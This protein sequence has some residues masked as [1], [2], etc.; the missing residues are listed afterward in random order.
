MLELFVGFQK[1]DTEGDRLCGLVARVS[2]NRSSGLGF[3]SRRY[4]IFWQVVSLERGPL[5]LVSTIEELRERKCSGSGPENQD[6]GR[7][8]PLRSPRDTPL[9][10]KVRTNF[11]DKRRSLGLYTKATETQRVLMKA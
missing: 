6:Y 7:K 5:S 1:T 8:D 3:D 10:A 11:A 4:Q 2:C 9:S